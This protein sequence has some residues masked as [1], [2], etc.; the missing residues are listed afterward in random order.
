MHVYIYVSTF[1]ITEIHFTEQTNTNWLQTNQDKALIQWIRVFVVVSRW[2][3]EELYMGK[4]ERKT[5]RHV[6]KKR[7]KPTKQSSQSLMCA[8]AHMPQKGNTTEKKGKW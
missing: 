7:T 5:K 6:Y 2:K 3:K 4:K 1:N 8:G